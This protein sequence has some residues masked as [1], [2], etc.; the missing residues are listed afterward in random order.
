MEIKKG[1]VIAPQPPPLINASVSC[2]PRILHCGA[3]ALPQ[4]ELHIVTIARLPSLQIPLT[5]VVQ[6]TLCPLAVLEYKD[7]HI[8]IYILYRYD[9]EI[10]DYDS[11]QRL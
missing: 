5:F 6:I 10:A 3:C 1:G 7:I 2:S 9:N 8:N 4:Y 11:I